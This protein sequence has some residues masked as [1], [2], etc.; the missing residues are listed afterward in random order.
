ML[1]ELICI[2]CGAGLA[3]AGSIAAATAVMAG[4]EAKN[5]STSSAS[6]VPQ[7]ANGGV[8]KG[9]TFA[10][11]GEG[12]YNE[13]VVPLGNSPQFESMKESIA[14][15]VIERSGGGA[16]QDL[17]ARPIVL[18]INGRELGRAQINDI[19]QIR[20]QVGVGVR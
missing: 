18:S 17:P 13:A 2:L 8:V 14:E 4:L 3:V 9:P 15:R 16:I 10:L 20:R 1:L 19:S 6:S 5:S 12:A 11:V 7:M